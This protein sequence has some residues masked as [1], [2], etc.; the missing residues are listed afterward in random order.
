MNVLQ[1]VFSG[2]LNERWKAFPDLTVAETWIMLPATV[3]M[4]VIGVWPQSIVGLINETMK[5]LAFRL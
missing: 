3:L 4:L 5:A 2:P 1:K